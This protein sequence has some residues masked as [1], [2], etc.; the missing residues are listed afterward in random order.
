MFQNRDPRKH[1]SVQNWKFF[2]LLP[3]HRK[4]INCKASTP[5]SKVAKKGGV[6]S[7]L[8]T[9]WLPDKRKTAENQVINSRFL[10]PEPSVT[11]Q[12]VKSI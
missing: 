11:T 10:Y 2:T 9:L 3:T 4:E 5:N 7:F 6:L 8:A 1:A 12:R